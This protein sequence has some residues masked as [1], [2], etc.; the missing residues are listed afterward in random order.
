HFAPRQRAVSFDAGW[1]DLRP[2]GQDRQ[3]EPE[4]AALAWL[5]LDPD[6][7]AMRFDQ[8]AADEEPEPH[9]PGR[10]L[11][12]AVHAVEA[13]EQPLGLLWANADAAIADANGQVAIYVIDAHG[14]WATVRRV[15]DRVVDPIGQ[16]L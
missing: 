12:R 8:A 6:A 10:A 2:I 7:S 15:L 16:D 1:H 14:D 13:L 11:Q 3:G 4:G 9:A 5:A